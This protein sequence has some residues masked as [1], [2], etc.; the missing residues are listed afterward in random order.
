MTGKV[1]ISA[2]NPNQPTITVTSGNIGEVGDSIAVVHT[3]DDQNAEVW[4]TRDELVFNHALVTEV[5]A[6]LTHWYGYTF[7]STDSSLMRQDVT[8]ALSTQS[9]ARA[10]AALEQV[11]NVS[12]AIKGDTIT[13]IP[14]RSG[15]T[16][17]IPRAKAYDVWTPSGE[18]G[19]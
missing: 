6:T 7:T 8:V 12:L 10:L 13:L 19:R 1:N 5:L 3:A 4:W 9:S 16:R 2:K 18:V 11:L 14:R 15:E 17:R